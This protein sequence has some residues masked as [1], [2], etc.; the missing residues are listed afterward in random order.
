[1]GILPILFFPQHTKLILSYFCSDQVIHLPF[2][3]VAA[4]LQVAPDT[5][6][7]GADAITP[8]PPNHPL[9]VEQGQQLGFLDSQHKISQINVNARLTLVRQPPFPKAL[10]RCCVQGPG[11]VGADEQKLGP[12]SRSWL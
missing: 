4:W 1:M 6:R 10:R 11:Q 2:C 8:P 12:L 7:F 5:L 3:E 9:M